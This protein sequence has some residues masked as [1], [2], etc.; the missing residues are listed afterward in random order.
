MAEHRWRKLHSLEVGFCLILWFHTPNRL[1]EQLGIHITLLLWPCSSAVWNVYFIAPLFSPDFPG[2]FSLH[3]AV[4]LTLRLGHEMISQ[5]ITPHFGC[6]G[7]ISLRLL[8]GWWRSSVSC[9]LLISFPPV[10]P[11]LCQDECAELYQ[12]HFVYVEMWSI[13]LINYGCWLGPLSHFNPHP[14]FHLLHFVS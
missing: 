3:S 9:Y 11:C 10:L 5:K 8:Q 4:D 2:Y 13:I 12:G 6:S 7:R 1:C 14:H